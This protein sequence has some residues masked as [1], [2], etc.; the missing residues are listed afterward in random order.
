MKIKDKDKYKFTIQTKI[1]PEI[2]KNFARFDTFILKKRWGFP[3]FF[4]LVF[5]ALCATLFMKQMNFFA[6]TSAV[7]A[8]AFPVIYFNTFNRIMRD[9][10]GNAPYG[11]II[12]DYLVTLT[13]DGVEIYSEEETAE[14]TWESLRAAYLLYNCIALYI[15]KDKPFLISQFNE[16]RYEKI[17]AYICEKAGSKAKDR[18]S[19]IC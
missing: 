7:I 17:W 6:M 9:N 14:C 11:A 4:F 3:A 2:Y 12:D 8:I 5:A 13:D 16:P 1:T 15:E 19:S 10:T 18:R